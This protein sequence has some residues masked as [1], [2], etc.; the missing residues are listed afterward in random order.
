MLS[1]EQIDKLVQHYG[2]MQG[3]QK[4]LIEHT[5]DF[6]EIE[7]KTAHYLLIA[8]GGALVSCVA[9][10]KDYSTAPYLKGMGLLISIFAYGFIAAAF[11]YGLLCAFRQSALD[12]IALG[13]ETFQSL[14]KFRIAP[15]LMLSASMI[16]LLGGILFLAH[17]LSVL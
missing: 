17:K 12:R 6:Y 2:G 1:Q 10:L 8:N 14:T 11:G 4:A 7:F 9:L 13:Q 16:L 3:F 15:W 5:R